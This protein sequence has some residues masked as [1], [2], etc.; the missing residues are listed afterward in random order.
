MPDP[1][2]RALEAICALYTRGLMVD[3]IIM[4]PV[5]WQQ[6]CDQ[7]YRNG[8]RLWNQPVILSDK[9]QQGRPMAASWGGY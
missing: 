5:D 1:A 6:I 9:V 3:A 2:E 7:H 4:N 8:L